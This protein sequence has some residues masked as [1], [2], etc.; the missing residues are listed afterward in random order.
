MNWRVSNRWRI[1]KVAG[2]WLASAPPSWPSVV[3]T[4]TFH[5]YYEAVDF[6][7]AELKVGSR[8]DLW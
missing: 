6:V 8:W 1:E 3:K 2:L 5:S 7:T 4:R